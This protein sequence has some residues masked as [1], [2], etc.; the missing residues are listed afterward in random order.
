[1]KPSALKKTLWTVAQIIGIL[2]IVGHFV[3]IQYISQYSFGL[4]LGGFG[5]LAL[6]TTLR[7]F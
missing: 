2:G 3:H 6:G 7:G 4:L 5:L 1:M